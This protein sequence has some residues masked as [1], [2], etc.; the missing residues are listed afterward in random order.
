MKNLFGMFWH[1]VRMEERRVLEFVRNGVG[2]ISSG[3]N[4]VGCGT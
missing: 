1:G 3:N 4:W 2:G